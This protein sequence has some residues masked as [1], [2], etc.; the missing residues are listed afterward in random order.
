GWA[1]QTSRRP[2]PA[3]TRSTAAPASARR[4]TSSVGA[5]APGPAARSSATTA[6]SRSVRRAASTTWWPCAASRRAVA[7]PIPLEAPVTRTI[8]RV[9]S[10]SMPR[11]S[12]AR[13]APG[14]P[15]RAWVRR[16]LP[17][18]GRRRYRRCDDREPAR[19]LPA[20]PP[21]AGLPAA[22]RADDARSPAGARAPPRGG[23]HGRRRQR[24]L[25][26]PPRAGPRAPPVSAGAGGARPRAAARRRRPRAPFRLAGIGPAPATA[27]EHADPALLRLLGQWPETPALVLGRAYD[28]L[29]ANRL[30]DALF[31][32]LAPGSNLMHRVFLDPRARSFYLDWEAAAE[33]AVAGFRVL[34]G[35]APRDPRVLV[36]L[37]EL[38]TGS[39]A[40]ARLWERHD[41]WGKRAETKGFPHP[42]VGEI[43]LRMTSFDVRSAPGQELV[44]YHA[45]PGSESA[46][47]LRL[48]GSLAATRRAERADD[49]TSAG[50]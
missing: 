10:V 44:V 23:G 36:V 9:V 2:C 46:D 24:R 28:V 26:R 7:S 18:R 25:L 15:R 22:G 3:S 14:R 29:A 41:A 4:V 49:A 27:G 38:L 6:S 39:P 13:P 40:F 32:G 35:S 50:S 1:P 21:C 31:D 30:A 33:N 37:E 17:R 5:S 47:A 8:F 43:V 20:G 48:L 45:E 11:R 12:P 19:G 42:P 34:H 16:I